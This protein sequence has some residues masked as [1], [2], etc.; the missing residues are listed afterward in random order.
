MK[1]TLLLFL[2][3]YLT[4]GLGQKSKLKRADRK[5]AALAYSEANTIY[6]GLADKGHKSDILF[7]KLGD[8]YFFN[9]D[10]AEAA[11]WYGKAFE[12]NK[13]LGT[14]YIYRY[15]Q[16]LKSQ[17]KYEEADALLRGYFTGKG[18]QYI[19]VKKIGEDASNYEVAELG[20]H[21]AGSQYPA[22]LGKKGTLY[23][24]SQGNGEKVVRWSGE[25]TSDLFQWSKNGLEPL[26]GEVNSP[27]NE[28]PI[29]IGKDGNTLY[30]TRNN[31]IAQTTGKDDKKIIR[32]K[33]YRAKRVNGAWEGVEELPFNSDA[34]SVGHPALSPD[35]SM[36]YFVSDM[37]INGSQGG[38][39]LY[40][41]PINEDG[42]FGDIENVTAL[43]TSG[44]EMFPFVDQNGTLYYA[45]NGTLP[46]W[47]GLDIYKAEKDMAK[48]NHLER[49]VNSNFDDFA[50]FT[51]SGGE[52]GYFASNRKTG[53]ED[54]IYTFTVKK[55]MPVAETPLPPAGEESAQQGL[56]TDMPKNK[57]AD[58]LSLA[59]RAI[60]D[61]SIFFGFDSS[62]L[63]AK[64]K[65]TL[66]QLAQVVRDHPWII[67][68]VASHADSRGPEGYNRKLSQRRGA[69]IQEHLSVN[70]IDPERITL[71]DFGETR[72]KINCSEERPCTEQQHAQNR[73][74]EFHVKSE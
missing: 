65:E 56:V 42:G 53:K 45:S 6:R 18:E 8:T 54:R 15:G 63:S 36:L 48:V 29:A 31:F 60:I 32:L 68:E 30:F 34:Y 51:N 44:D 24:V 62:D 73:R 5:M 38:T 70:G 10:Y 47:G 23:V 46:N 50:L 33:L 43:N 49:P 27:Y 14:E 3:L 37:K 11:K 28:G 66:V 2:G 16:S 41:V 21:S 58:A 9:A 52:R 72:L 67:L 39:D 12:I 57:G 1:I 13:D 35:E 20:G 22:Y 17:E 71:I 55:K 69:S 59:E 74:S 61:Q 40:R 19:P 64:A 7:K 26:Q 4:T 25:P